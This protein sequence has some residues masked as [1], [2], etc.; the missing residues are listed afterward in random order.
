M[1]W[2]RNLIPMLTNM[3]PS[4]EM[5]GGEDCVDNACKGF[6]L[7]HPLRVHSK[8]PLGMLRDRWQFGCRVH[9]LQAQVSWQCYCCWSPHTLWIIRC[10]S[11]ALWLPPWALPLHFLFVQA[12]SFRSTPFPLLR[13]SFLYMVKPI[14]HHTSSHFPFIWSFCCVGHVLLVK[15]GTQPSCFS[16]LKWLFED[17]EEHSYVIIQ[18]WQNAIILKLFVECEKFLLFSLFL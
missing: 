13:S 16:Q 8:V 5:C 6:C 2:V 9:C 14:K 12:P 10:C 7:N 1:G 11:L 15:V 17:K 4:S 18:V 3:G